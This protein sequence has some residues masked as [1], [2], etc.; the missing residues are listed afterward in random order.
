MQKNW[1]NQINPGS[2]G[3]MGGPWASPSSPPFPLSQPPIKNKGIKGKN[4]R[5]VLW[6]PSVLPGKR[7]FESAVEIQ[8]KMLWNNSS[9]QKILSRCPVDLSSRDTWNRLKFGHSQGSI[10]QKYITSERTKGWAFAHRS[11]SL[12]VSSCLPLSLWLHHSLSL[13]INTSIGVNRA[14]NAA[15]MPSICPV[16]LLQT[17]APIRETLVALQADGQSNKCPQIKL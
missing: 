5:L 15:K 17:L 10:N 4:S 13:C 16:D 8:K 6:M 9:G 2:P 7:Y 12:S 14:E 3:R 11:S 1:Q